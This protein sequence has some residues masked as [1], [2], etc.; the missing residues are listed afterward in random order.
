MDI[1]LVYSVLYQNCELSRY[2]GIK[3]VEPANK[4]DRDTRYHHLFRREHEHSPAAIC[5]FAMMECF[6]LGKIIV[7][8]FD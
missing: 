7:L 1:K 6:I 5:E 8:F 4:A 2:G 3:S